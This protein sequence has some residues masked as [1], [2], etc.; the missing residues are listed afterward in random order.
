MNILVFLIILVISYKLFGIK[1][2]LI[3]SA[4]GLLI[5]RLSGEKESTVNEKISEKLSGIY[6]EKST[7]ELY[8]QLRFAKSNKRKIILNEISKRLANSLQETLDQAINYD[9]NKRVKSNLRVF[10]KRAQVDNNKDTEWN[11]L[12]DSWD[13]RIS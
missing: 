3:V 10:P 7:E 6:S 9:Q 4:V 8:N 5:I 11:F 2:L 1:G 12:D 13:D